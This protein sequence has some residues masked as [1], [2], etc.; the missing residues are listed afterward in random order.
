MHVLLRHNIKVGGTV[1]G[2]NVDPAFSNAL[3]TLILVDLTLAD[4]KLLE[5]TMGK[6][7]AQAY[8]AFHAANRSS[9]RA[10]S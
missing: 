8:P 10:A 7:E 4:P 2:F 3:D 9:A 1:L 5:K 6:E